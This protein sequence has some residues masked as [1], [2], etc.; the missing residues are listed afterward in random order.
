MQIEHPSEKEVVFT[1]TSNPGT[2]DADA[3]MEQARQ[4]LNGQ[5]TRAV[6]DLR[7]LEM[8]SS[9]GINVAVS[10][11]KNMQ[12]LGG[13]MEVQVPDERMVRVFELFRLTD[14]FPVRVVK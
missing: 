11:Y 7:Q 8:V 1:F 5:E 6:V 2:A 10:I 3:W 14:L 12:S 4:A 9:L 13:E